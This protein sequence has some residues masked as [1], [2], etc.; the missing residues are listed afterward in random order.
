MT[1]RTINRRQFMGF[2]AGTVGLVA[3]GGLGALLLSACEPPGG[4]NPARNRLFVPPTRTVNGSTL[5][6]RA[7]RIDL[8]GGALSIVRAYD[9]M[10]PGPTFVANRGDLAAIDFTNSLT[11][12]TTVHWH[13]M[14]VPTAADG[15]PHEVVAPGGAYR[16]EFPVIQRAGL[17]FYH[18]HPHL[19]TAQQVNLGLAGGFIVRDPEEAALGLPR[20]WRE[21]PLVLRDASFDSAG[22]LKY[23]ASGSGFSGSTPLANGTRDAKLG[24]DDAL[25]RFRI[26][27]GSNA[28]VFRLGLSNGQPFTIIGND[29]GLLAQPVSA[30]QITI[31][32]GERLDLLVDF[33]GL[34]V[35]QRVMLRC[36]DAGWDLVEFEVTRAVTNSQ[37]PPT[38]AISTIETLGTPVRT[39][40]FSF[41]GMG[42]IN[43]QAYDMHRTDFQ[44]PFGDVERWRFSTG[45]NAPHPV[46]VHGASFQVESRTGGRG[47]VLP[48]ERG[49]KDTVL[50]ADG[51]TVDV[52]IRFDGYRGRYLIHCHQLEHEDRGMMQNFEVV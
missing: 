5:T 2:S 25:Y 34:A 27:Q 43:G 39:R 10:V 23:Q 7:A 44:V 42:K 12:P 52:L 28:R 21:V 32:P 31:G 14:V 48:W 45:G 26:V 40:T 49:W 13:G 18:P 37:T 51:E 11:D 46:H 47:V 24:V 3:T 19:M 6:A 8:G 9:G 16:Y 35:G 17:N 20:D 41:D 15:Q 36:L 33:R 4:T 29:G 30:T 1:T 22:N 50:L 38:G